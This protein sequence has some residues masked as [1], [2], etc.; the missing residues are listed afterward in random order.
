MKET[1]HSFNDS[2]DISGDRFDLPQCDFDRSNEC[3][4][5]DI[6]R[7]VD[8]LNG[9]NSTKPWLGAVLPVSP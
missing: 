5:A 2:G 3:N 8:L 9:V 6:L 4:P 1:P 7:L